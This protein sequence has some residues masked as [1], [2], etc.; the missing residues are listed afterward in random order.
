VSAA[1]RVARTL[2]ATLL[3]ALA[4]CQPQETRSGLDLSA[5]STAAARLAALEAELEMKRAELED[6]RRRRAELIEQTVPQPDQPS[7]RRAPAA[8][9]DLPNAAPG[10]D[11]PRGGGPVTAAG[12]S[13]EE[14]RLEAE[15]ARLLVALGKARPSMP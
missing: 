12:L 6:V 14:Q 15:V 9:T 13:D 3:V 11:L 5:P 10:P 7:G 1:G 2:A 4:A 8:A